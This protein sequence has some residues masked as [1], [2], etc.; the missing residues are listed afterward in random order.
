MRGYTDPVTRTPRPRSASVARARQRGWLGLVALLIGLAIVGW[1]AM[2]AL[3][4][5]GVAGRPAAPDDARAV[6]ADPRERARSVEALVV[7]QSREALR[8]ADESGEGK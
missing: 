3:K 7:E 6:P 8:R 2:S 1:L 5:L 4:G